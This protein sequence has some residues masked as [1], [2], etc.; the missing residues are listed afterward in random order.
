MERERRVLVTGGCGYVGSVLVPKLAQRYSVIVLD[1]LLFGNC[2]DSTPNIT[3]VQ[4]DLRDPNL[5]WSLLAE[6]TDVIHLASIAND[7]CS[8][9]DPILTRE[10]NLQATADLVRMARERGV[11]RFIYASSSSVYGVQDAPSVTEDLSLNPITLYARYK[12]ES[13]KI[14]AEASG[15]GFTAVSVRSATV[16]GV[17]PRM[18][19]DVIVNMMAKMALHPGVITVLGGD[20][21]RP[22][23]HIEDITDLYALLLAVPPEKVQGQV[24][25]AGAANHTVLEIARMAQAE[26]GGRMEVDPHTPDPRSYRI[27]SHKIR[28]ALGFRPRHPIRQAIR[29]IKEAFA[30]GMFPDPDSD[31]YYNIRTM[32]KQLPART[33]R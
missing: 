17:S 2:L 13:E 9:L 32:K 19:F 16:C 28:Q 29:D 1:S 3:V 25:N 20:Q 11:Q 23:I 15:A 18:R 12:A 8:D 5:V 33:T 21:Q 30:R 4:G 10:V 14:V 31:A 24:F 27:T 6:A 22:N 7:P 26:I